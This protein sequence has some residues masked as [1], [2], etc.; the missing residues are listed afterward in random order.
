MKFVLIIL[1][2]L[3]GVVGIVAII[4]ALLP[5]DHVASMTVTVVAPP[6]RVWT[7]ITDVG[8]HPTW[9]PELKSVEVVSRSPLSW[10]EVSGTGTMTLVADE[11]RPPS[12]MVARIT[13][14]N[15]PFGGEWEYHI[16]ADSTNPDKT[17]V[18]ITERGWVSNPIFRF[19]SKFVMG[20]E[21]TIDT[22][23]RALSRE[24]GPEATPATATVPAT[25][26]SP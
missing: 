10:K 12:R 25:A 23:L 21:S 18:T 17:H 6:L 22:Y 24:F 4:G 8:N 15:Q 16:A 3:V 9:R 13:D 1:G 2:F 26:S 5:R 7:T 19:V 20:H 11:L 14:D